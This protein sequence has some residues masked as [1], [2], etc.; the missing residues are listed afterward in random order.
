MEEASEGSPALAAPPEAAP[1][2][3]ILQWNVQGLR[4]K[5]HQVLQAAIEDELD[6]VLLQ[7]TLTPANFEW[8]VAGY[9]LHSLAATPEG[10]RGC[11]ALVRNT[12]PHRRIPHPVYCGDGVEVLAL[13][14]HVGGGLLNIYSLYR[15]QTHLLEAGELLALAEQSSLLVAGDFNAHHTLLQSVSRT[16]ETGRHL[17]VL[18]EEA[19]HVRLLNTGEPTHIRG[20][21]L[22]LTLASTDLAAGATWQVHPTLTSD[23]FATLTTLALA[24]PVPPRPLPRWDVRR[25]D[26][27]RFQAALEEWW[28]VYQPPGDIHQQEKDLTAAIQMAADAAI[29]RT[30]PGRRRRPD[31]WFYSEEVREHNHRVNVHRKLHKR[32]PSA[33][34]LK[35][36]QDVVTRAREVSQRAK[37][38]KWLEWC[39]TFSQHTSLGQLW[40]RVHT[41]TGGAPP[42]PAAHPHP[43]QEAERLIAAFTARGSSE[44]LPPN[45][46]HLQHQLRPHRDAATREACEEPD[47]TDAA[48]TP[49][50][51][52]RAHR[53]RRDTAAGADGVTYAML[54]HAG[55]AGSAAVLSLINV[56]W[57]SGR[58]P[59]A[60]KEADIQPIPKPREPTKMRPISLTSCAAKIA[61]RMV[62][63][64]LQWR[65]GALHPHVFGFTRGVSTADSIIT[66]LTEANHR[67]TIAVFL[68]LEKAFELA[69]PHAILAALVR[70][71]VRGRLLAWLKDYLLH[72]RARVRFQGHKSSFCELE[73]GTP[74]GGILS[75][76]LFNLL[77]EQLVALP[78]Q[79]GAVLLS[80]ADDLALVV[81]GRGNHISKAQRALDLI[82]AK[83]E[84]LGLKISAEKSRAMAIRSGSPAN[85]LHV[86]GMELAWTRTY[87]YLG[88]WL[89]SRLSFAAQLTY[90]RERT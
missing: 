24:P 72:R 37:E 65:V 5:R 33:T 66:L 22:D 32:R 74:Q 16:N 27:P 84:E 44:Q 57:C 87:Q 11:A 43:R 67:P 71:G 86:Q 75:P 38:A 55:L 68:D 15:S 30:S 83:C 21:R 56:S 28:A 46:R 35:L 26:W 34:T 7:E 2:L 51:L 49:Q 50:E 59:L 10:G 90:L 42:R 79:E 1:R 13:E 23:H 12:I 60:W 3:K 8:R 41:A 63:S 40:R 18:L 61:E 36:L 48:F 47:A 69:S 45:T 19:P 89:D 31:W 14:L 17:A 54:A 85:Q 25:A 9:T 4:P 73:N 64:R 82:T 81:S 53:R 78:F 76:F 52:A 58:L 39:S 80:Y 6:V 77:M 29:P 88:V 62:L 70:K 20:G